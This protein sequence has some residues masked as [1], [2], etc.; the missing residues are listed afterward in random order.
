MKVKDADLWDKVSK[1][2]TP[3]NSKE[4]KSWM[5]RVRR[6]FSFDCILPSKLDL[7]GMTLQQAYD[8]TYSFL[9]EHSGLGTPKVIVITGKG[10]GGEGKLKKEFPFWLEK[11]ELAEK[12]D[13]FEYAPYQKGGDGAVII[14]LKRRKNVR[15]GN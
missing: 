13:R 8:A 4:K 3:L 14:Y 2:V 1:T 10:K 12:I 5:S 6:F 9:L 11:K 7:H 15:N